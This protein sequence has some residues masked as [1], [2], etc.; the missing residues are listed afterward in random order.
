MW[1]LWNCESNTTFN[2]AWRKHR[3]TWHKQTTELDWRAAGSFHRELQPFQ[4]HI[5]KP[6]W[7]KRLESSRLALTEQCIM[8]RL[9]L[10]V[11]KL[12][13]VHLK[14][15]GSFSMACVCFA[16]CFQ[17]KSISSCST[18]TVS[19]LQRLHAFFKHDTSET[20]QEGKPVDWQREKSHWDVFRELAC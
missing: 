20:K 3:V 2:D 10:N 12:A 19:G 16:E 11:A 17:V 8:G 18:V 9:W 7:L 14:C 1:F 15:V 6:H 5:N 13:T 4:L